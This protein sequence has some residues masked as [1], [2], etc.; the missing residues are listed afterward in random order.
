MQMRIMKHIIVV[1]LINF[2][3]FEQNSSC[4]DM[5]GA[6][7]DC[8]STN[9]ISFPGIPADIPT[10]TD[11]NPTF[12]LLHNSI[13]HFLKEYKEKSPNKTSHNGMCG[14]I[15][16]MA[17]QHSRGVQGT[18]NSHISQ[19]KDQY[20]S[21]FD[22]C[23]VG[24][25]TEKDGEEWNTISKINTDRNKPDQLSARDSNP[26]T[27]LGQGRP[28]LRRTPEYRIDNVSSISEKE[29]NSI[30]E[31]PSSFPSSWQKGLEM[32][33]QKHVNLS[34]KDNSSSISPKKPCTSQIAGI[35]PQSDPVLEENTRQQSTLL[36]ASPCKESNMSNT[37]ENSPKS[38]RRNLPRDGDI[39]SR[40]H[41][42][43][44]SKSGTETTSNPLRTSAVDQ[45]FPHLNRN[46]I[47]F[48]KNGKSLQRFMVRSDG[49][50][51][52]IKQVSAF[53][54]GPQQHTITQQK[55]STP[56]HLDANSFEDKFG[57][58]K[59]TVEEEYYKR[60]Q[61][62]AQRYTVL[63]PRNGVVK[64]RPPLQLGKLALQARA[65]RKFQYLMAL[66]F[67]RYF[68]HEY[69]RSSHFY[70]TENKGTAR[71]VSQ[72]FGN[73]DI[74]KRNTNQN[75]GAI[76]SNIMNC[77]HY[78]RR[79]L[80][81]DFDNCR[82]YLPNDAGLNSYSEKV[83]YVNHGIRNDQMSSSSTLKLLQNNSEYIYDGSQKYADLDFATS[84]FWHDRIQH[85]G[86]RN[87]NID[88]MDEF[89]D[90]S[91][92]G[93]DTGSTNTPNAIRSE[94]PFNSHAR[95]SHGDDRHR[96][97]VNDNHCGYMFDDNPKESLSGRE[98]FTIP[99]NKTG[100]YPVRNPFQNAV[101]DRI[102]YSSLLN[103]F[104]EAHRHS[105]FRPTLPFNDTTMVQG[106][107]T[108]RMHPQW[109]LDAHVQNGNAP[110]IHYPKS[111]QLSAPFTTD[112]MQ[113]RGNNSLSPSLDPD[114]H[115]LPDA[116]FAYNA[117]KSL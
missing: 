48:D 39:R 22:V 43:Y 87:S 51:C 29:F 112:M 64:N 35:L 105:A 104:H 1:F 56:M 114:V 115:R 88:D 94:N 31:H 99:P 103:S 60:R 41:K 10:K 50:I 36:T 66:K 68:L 71:R 42:T 54:V 25:G 3:E 14:Q 52:P 63:G 76:G 46:T 83:S 16:G 38:K 26:R 81:K 107:N 77:Q 2:S 100:D 62:N 5:T 61:M 96:L 91:T 74:T 102:G 59:K 15:G 84:D 28:M 11:S 69:E 19:Y 110:E 113:N 53:S 44:R 32:K 89:I 82:G 97:T 75:Y 8:D 21:N 40:F 65:F 18:S 93:L 108:E 24:P 72:T 49:I 57:K 90:R 7:K 73:L 95:Q 101:D 4:Q 27:Q 85:S 6:S 109:E 33:Q 70:G 45:N 79:Q 92:R 37:E 13:D 67:R 12:S 80:L 98:N 17:E 47:L 117:P 20:N 106:E 30:R 34:D 111:Q 23:Q 9:S 116:I 78:T 86:N 55:S 58:E